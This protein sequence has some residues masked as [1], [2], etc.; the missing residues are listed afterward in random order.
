MIIGVQHTCIHV[1]NFERSLGFY[2]DILGLRERYRM[3][4]GPS[5]E[6]DKI[7]GV[8]GVKL[9][10][11]HLEAGKG[12]D[13]ELIEYVTPKG[14]P[15]ERNQQDFGNVHIAFYVD[16]IHKT[17]HDLMEKG[18]KFVTAPNESNE[19]PETGV[20]MCYFHDPDGVLLELMEQ[21]YWWTARQNYK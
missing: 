20:K 2:R 21:R 16:D 17:H 14:R 15:V 10:I 19:G 12:D 13:I 1:S 8:E 5:S 3:E 9:K 6:L 4:L 11:V 18:V 7:I